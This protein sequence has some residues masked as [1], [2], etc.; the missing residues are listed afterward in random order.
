MR[1]PPASHPAD[2]PSLDADEAQNKAFPST[3]IPISHAQIPGNVP[4]PPRPPQLA[5]RGSHCACSANQ[6]PCGVHLKRDLGLRQAEDEGD[7]AP[8]LL[9]VARY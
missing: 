5:A 3:C 2:G 1:M 9:G 6:Q 4:T 7:D 8:I